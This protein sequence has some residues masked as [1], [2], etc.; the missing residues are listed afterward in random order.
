MSAT[1][2]A[3]ADT[4]PGAG[5]APGAVMMPQSDNASPPSV[6]AGTGSARGGSCPGLGTSEAS[7]AG[8]V[9]SRYRHASGA[10]PGSAIA[11]GAVVSSAA[12]CAVLVFGYGPRRW[13]W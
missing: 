6:V 12:A 4:S 8:G 1:S 10:A 2:H 7:T 5:G 11:V 9:V 3:S 13:I